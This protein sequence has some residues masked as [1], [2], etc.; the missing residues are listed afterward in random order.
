MN[1]P[2]LADAARIA[3]VR[4]ADVAPTPW[5]NGGGVGRDLLLWPTPADV[6]VRIN[7]ADIERSGPFSDFS[8]WRRLFALVDG[9]PVELTVD[10]AVHQVAPGGSPCLFDGGA[11]T[12]CR[13]LGGPAR[14]LNLVVRQATTA[15]VRGASLTV[16][17][18]GGGQVIGGQRVGAQGAQADSICDATELVAMYCHSTLATGLFDAEVTSIGPQELLARVVAPGTRV[19]VRVSAGT[20]AG[21]AAAGGAA[22][23]MRVPLD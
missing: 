15:S 11:A 1:T 23:L 6:Q 17:G 16:V 7:V 12:A 4:V 5:R 10:G 19:C 8:G 13:L 22:W 3:R 21:Q 2:H 14:A 20:P 9:D 18:G